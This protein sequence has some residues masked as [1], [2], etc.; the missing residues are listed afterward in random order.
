ME[1]LSHVEMLV[2]IKSGAGKAVR[3]GRRP[4][5]KF[6]LQKYPSLMI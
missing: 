6:H 1:M 2:N 4:W 5:K 3:Q